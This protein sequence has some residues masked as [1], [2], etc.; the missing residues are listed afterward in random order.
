MKTTAPALSYVVTN[1]IMAVWA[2][3]L[4]GMIVGT[5]DF[6][7]DRELQCGRLFGQAVLLCRTNAAYSIDAGMLSKTIWCRCAW[8][9]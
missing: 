9:P 3:I 7:G 2:F 4:I 5:L 6:S 1:V 8:F